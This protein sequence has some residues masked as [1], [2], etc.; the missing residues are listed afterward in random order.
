MFNVFKEI[1]I[2]LLQENLIIKLAVICICSILIFGGCHY[3]NQ[4]MGLQDDNEIEEFVEKIIEQKT[5]FDVDLTPL[6]PE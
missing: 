1:Y 3:L 2:H 5:G 4:K 6:S